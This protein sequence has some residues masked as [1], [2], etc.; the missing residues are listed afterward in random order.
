MLTDKDSPEKSITVLL[1]APPFVPPPLLMAT[2]KVV[3][4]TVMPSMP[5]NEASPTVALTAVQLLRSVPTAGV[6][7]AFGESSAIAISTSLSDRPIAD[8]LSTG[9]FTPAKALSICAPI[10]IRSTSSTPSPAIPTTLPSASDTL[11]NADFSKKQSPETH[12]KSKILAD[13]PL[14]SKR[15]VF[16]AIS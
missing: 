8:P 11:S 3:T 13:N 1:G 14:T 4:E 7:G 16:A 10:C 15:T 6:A 9:P 2:P 5:M 12:K